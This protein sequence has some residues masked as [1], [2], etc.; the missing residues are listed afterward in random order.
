MPRVKMG[1][2]GKN[3]GQG[4]LVQTMPF[5]MLKNLVGGAGT[6]TE[7]TTLSIQDSAA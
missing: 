3:D 6:S 4:G 5:Q 7:A 2:A 1:G